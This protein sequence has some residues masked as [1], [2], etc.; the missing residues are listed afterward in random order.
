MVGAL[1][2]SRPLALAVAKAVEATDLIS[3]PSSCASNRRHLRTSTSKFV[4]RRS[5]LH[6]W[7]L[8]LKPGIY[9]GDY[10]SHVG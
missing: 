7:L 1:S 6:L 3:L 9:Q 4:P 2:R 10:E 5:C 8:K